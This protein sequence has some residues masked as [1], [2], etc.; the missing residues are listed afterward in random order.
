MNVVRRFRDRQLVEF[1]I[2]GVSQSIDEPSLGQK[3]RNLAG[4]VGR[5][6]NAVI[7]QKIVSVT[8]EERD[9]RMSICAICE[10]YTGTTC[11]KCGCYIRFKAKLETEHCPIH[12]W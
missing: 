12:K 11:K 6:I 4:A 2:N 10:F 8:D 1:T 7:Q 5:V 9:R 3:A